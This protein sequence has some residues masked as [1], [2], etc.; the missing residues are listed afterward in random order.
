MESIVYTH[1]A[2]S[3]V[4]VPVT[5]AVAIAAW[6]RR[7]RPTIFPFFGL[8]AACA[9]WSAAGCLALVSPTE[10]S[11]R[12]WQVPVRMIAVTLV[13]LFLLAFAL[14]YSGRGAWLRPR[15]FAWLALVP[16]TTLVLNVSPLAPLLIRKVGFER[17][18]PLLVGERPETGPWFPVHQLY[19]YALVG[20]A[21]ALLVLQIARS[22]DFYRR[23]AITLFCGLVIPVAASSVA[24]LALARQPGSSRIWLDWTMPSFTLIGL[25]WSWALFRQRLLD[26]MPVALDTVFASMN[27][28]VLVLDLEARVVD[29]NPA[30]S[31]LVGRA[32]SETIGKLLP[33]IASELSAVVAHPGVDGQFE[34]VALH[35]RVLEL[36]VSPLADERHGAIGQLA[37]LRD[38]TERARLMR[39]LDAYAR[40]VA[41]DLK[42]PIAAVTGYADVIL[43]SGEAFDA[44]TR[45]YLSSISEVGRGMAETVE[46][47]LLLARVRSADEVETAILDMGRLVERAAQRLA[48]EVE[49]RDAQLV[50]AGAWPAARGYGAWVE[51]IWAN[52]LSN[53]LKYGG[54]PPRVEA[55]ATGGAGAPRFWVRDNGQ[56]LSP[57]SRRR[58]FREFERL[59]AANAEGHGLGLSIVQRIAEKLGGAVG[60]DSEPGRGSTF[61]FT[62]P[63]A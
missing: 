19:S 31:A 49:R 51:E 39:D 24:N 29:L 12:F 11:A 60:V 40:T 21:L 59:A 41:H 44:E 38:I 34:E 42:N 10:P 62:L 46:G 32:R 54:T 27:D 1:A 47:L 43:G 4:A 58:L 57:E 33:E 13:P 22:R 5:L 2:F 6:R 52:L 3:F 18:G 16:A 28:A 14:E 30:G 23:Q 35:G 55:G 25:S 26:V 50:I 56:G 8:M 48:G 36:R 17:M 53:A 45:R 15:R 37:V 61:W 20:T 7:N 63:P 9:L